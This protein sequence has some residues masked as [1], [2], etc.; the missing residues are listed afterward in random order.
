VR[1]LEEFGV[2]K[3]RQNLTLRPIRY[4]QREVQDEKLFGHIV[5]STF[6]R[7]INPRMT[8]ETFMYD[9]AHI[10]LL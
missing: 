9:V 8:P 6:R 2:K 3:I 5:V 1:R 10:N 4:E 7:E